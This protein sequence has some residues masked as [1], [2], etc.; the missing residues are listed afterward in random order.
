MRRSQGRVY[1]L[2]ETVFGRCLAA[3]RQRNSRPDRSSTT[4]VDIAA[5]RLVGIGCALYRRKT[6]VALRSA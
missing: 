6:K 5:P 1:E 4:C 2:D 3:N